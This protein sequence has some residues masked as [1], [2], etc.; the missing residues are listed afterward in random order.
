MCGYQP[1][2]VRA[3]PQAPDPMTAGRVIAAQLAGRPPRPIFLS[4]SIAVGLGNAASDIDV[5]VIEANGNASRQ[6]VFAEDTRVDVHYIPYPVLQSAV[7]RVLGLRLFAV[8]PDAGGSVAGADVMLAVHL[9]QGEIVHDDGQLAQLCGRLAGSPL[10]LRRAVINHWVLSAAGCYED[11]NGLRDSTAADDQDAALLIAR[12]ALTAAAKAV[13]AAEGDLHFGEKWVWHQL[14]RSAPAGFAQEHCRRLMR[15]DPLGQR[16][17]LRIDEIMVFAQTCIAA[18]TTLG[19][20]GV[21]LG[22]W[23][24]WRGSEGPL[25]R[26]A[27]YAVRPYQ[28]GLVLMGPGSRHVRLKPDVALVWALADGVCAADL[29]TA[30]SRL[31]HASPAYQALDSGR[32]AALVSRL[33]GAGLIHDSAAGRAG[34]TDTAG[35]WHAL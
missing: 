28:D 10:T 24:T 13:A 15:A 32:C 12:A 11:W 5:Y 18:A 23:P 6:Q 8:G 35:D 17:G 4:G 26:D 31:R 21:S 14:A 9:Y 7:D 1:G 22:Q 3:D 25:A 20:Q 16:A 27:S 33:A 30:A 2:P 34:R 29:A 19:W